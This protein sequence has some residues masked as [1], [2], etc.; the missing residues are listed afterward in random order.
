MS[1]SSTFQCVSLSRLS[2]MPAVGGFEGYAI[3]T[4]LPGIMCYGLFV[5]C[6][7]VNCPLNSQTAF[8]VIK[9][10]KYFPTL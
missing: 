8:V 3:E 9:I 10:S 7:E 2:T 4:L 6:I 1:E 5:I